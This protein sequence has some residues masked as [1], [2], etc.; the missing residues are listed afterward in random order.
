MTP[1]SST[2]S[3]V[4]SATMTP[5]STVHEPRCPSPVIRS[6]A[7]A[8]RAASP[9]D[10]AS[11]SA[12]QHRTTPTQQR[13]RGCRV[14]SSQRPGAASW[15]RSRTGERL[16]SPAA[17]ANARSHCLALR[18]WSCFPDAAVPRTPQRVRRRRR[19]GHVRRG[20]CVPRV[21]HGGS[22]GCPG[23][24]GVFHARRLES[25]QAPRH[26]SGR[27][28]R[29]TSLPSGTVWQTPSGPDASPRRACSTAAA[30]RTT[31]RCIRLRSG[32]VDW[33]IRI[34]GSR[35]NGSVKPPSVP[36]A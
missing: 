19:V 9:M 13:T 12:Q 26:R 2:P 23:V 24:T 27:T 5:S 10:G 1:S 4:P 36:G 33:R 7:P 28:T 22:P 20:H 18:C 16:S 35:R 21:A 11:M 14:E 34:A 32:R 31:S 8:A 29:S 30:G 3:N 25:S 17:R 15:S 6:R